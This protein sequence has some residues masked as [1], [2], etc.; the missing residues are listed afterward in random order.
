[1]ST[2]KQ[3]F[4]GGMDR[5]RLET[6]MHTVH[7]QYNKRDLEKNLNSSDLNGNNFV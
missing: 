1:M 6:Q 4:P 7:T 3:K 2:V 5:M